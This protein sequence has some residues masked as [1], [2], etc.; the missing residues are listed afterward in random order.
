MQ[1]RIPLYFQIPD[2][3]FIGQLRGR[4]LQDVPEFRMLARHLRDPSGDFL[5]MGVIGRPI[6]LQAL[7]FFRVEVGDGDL[8]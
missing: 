7:Y 3:L 5:T 8:W 1:D 4:A 2:A 6:I